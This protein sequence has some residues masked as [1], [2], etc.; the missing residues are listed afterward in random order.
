[1]R[2]VGSIAIVHETLSHT[3]DELV[4]FD[5]IADRVMAMAGEVSATGGAGARRAGSGAFG[6]L[7][8][9]IA[10]PLAMVL[11]ELLQNALEHGWRNRPGT[12][13]VIGRRGRRSGSTSSSPTTGAAC[14][15]G[16]TWSSATTW[17]CRSCGRWSW[18]SWAS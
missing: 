8:A 3:P 5:D 10:T 16:S 1:M 15:P 18:G 13:E 14:P 4:D 17:A 9:E 12:L 6:M 7:P 11:T 2:R